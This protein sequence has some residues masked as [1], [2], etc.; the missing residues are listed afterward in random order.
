VDHEQPEDPLRSELCLIDF[1]PCNSINNTHQH[2]VATPAVPS[3]QP[4][5]ATIS[6]PRHP[7]MIHCFLFPMPLFPAHVK[8]EHGSL[9][10]MVDSVPR[11]RGRGLSFS[12]ALV[13]SARNN[14]RMPVAYHIRLAGGMYFPSGHLGQCH[15]NG[16]VQQTMLHTIHHVSASHQSI[17]VP[18]T[19]LRQAERGA[20]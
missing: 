16:L 4:F 8:M 9:D 14:G 6:C 18:I 2:H 7:H 1:C 11:R 12:S 5:R 13:A 17:P 3:Q 15:D 19:L 10:I 20:L